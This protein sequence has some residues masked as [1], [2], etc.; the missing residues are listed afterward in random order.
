M[1]YLIPPINSS[2]RFK[3]NA[4]FADLIHENVNYTCTAIRTLED[5]KA[6]GI[7]AAGVIYSPVGLG[8]NDY[9]DDLKSG[10]PIVT[11]KN[12]A[13]D[14]YDIPGDMFASIPKVVGEIFVGKFIAVD[15]GN[16]PVGHDVTPITNDIIDVVKGHLGINP[17]IEVLE[18]TATVMVPDGTLREFKTRVRSATSSYGGSIRLQLSKARNVINRLKSDIVKYKEYIKSHAGN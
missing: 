9:K 18:S 4:P 3:V 2:G 8:V 17:K 5:I 7:D 10:V 15:I 13:G 14:S 12:D 11:L 16:L 1:S 6:S